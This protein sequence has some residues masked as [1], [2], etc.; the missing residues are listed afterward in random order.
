MRR[1]PTLLILTCCLAW[2]ACHSSDDEGV[3]PPH[4]LA[5]K[6]LSFTSQTESEEIGVLEPGDAVGITVINELTGQ[7]TTVNAQYIVDASGRLVGVENI[8]FPDNGASISLFAYA[9]YREDWDNLTDDSY[10]IVEVPTMQELYEQY[11]AADLIIGLPEGGNPVTRTD[12]KMIF[13]HAFS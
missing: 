6:E 13:S 7:T 5:G 4:E 1:N 9:P 11:H 8:T 10:R 3:T 12:V 2:S